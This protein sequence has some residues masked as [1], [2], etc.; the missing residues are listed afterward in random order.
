[1]ALSCA[2]LIRSRMLITRWDRGWQRN[3]PD[4]LLSRSPVFLRR[5]GV[6][7]GSVLLRRALMRHRRGMRLR[8]I[9]LRLSLSRVRFFRGVLAL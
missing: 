8:R 4:P 3:P 1:M 6:M 7:R 9:R 5:T 2:R